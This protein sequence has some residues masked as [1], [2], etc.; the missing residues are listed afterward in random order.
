MSVKDL[1]NGQLT[2]IQGYIPGGEALAAVTD[3]ARKLRKNNPKLLYLLDRESLR[4]Y[5]R[6]DAYID[7]LSLQ[8][9]LVMQA[10][11]MSRQM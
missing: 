6:S 3:L 10:N 5:R 2:H 8:R 1:V 9:C 4:L 7:I 11:F